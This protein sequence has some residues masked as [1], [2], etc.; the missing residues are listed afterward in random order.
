MI[1]L[2]LAVTTRWLGTIRSRSSAANTTTRRH[3]SAST[4]TT[5]TAIGCGFHASFD[6][7]MLVNPLAYLLGISDEEADKVGSRYTNE[8]LDRYREKAAQES[9]MDPLPGRWPRSTTRC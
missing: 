4:L 6:P 7:P 5:C 2:R 1:D 3:P 9:R 8:S